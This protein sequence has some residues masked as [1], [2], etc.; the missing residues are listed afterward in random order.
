MSDAP[1]VE[2]AVKDVEA[3][4][5]PIERV[6]NAAAIQPTNLLLDQDLGEIHR[7]MQVNYGGL[8][9]VTKFALPRMLGRPRLRPRSAPPPRGPREPQPD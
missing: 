3:R 2:Q 1:A 7:V 5:G 6:Y 9:N 4:L 8:V